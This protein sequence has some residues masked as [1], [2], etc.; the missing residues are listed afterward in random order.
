MYLLKN[1]P[2]NKCHFASHMLVFYLS[3]FRYLYWKTRQKYRERNDFFQCK[4][5]LLE[6]ILLACGC[7]HTFG[8]LVN[9]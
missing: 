1:K 4:I 9:L 3:M 2:C 7:P 6:W 5:Q 8:H